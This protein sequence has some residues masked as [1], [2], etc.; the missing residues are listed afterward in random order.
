MDKE[1]PPDHFERN[2]GE[3]SNRKRRYCLRLMAPSD[4]GNPAHS[5]V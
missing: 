3:V 5:R 4:L 2:T 1:T